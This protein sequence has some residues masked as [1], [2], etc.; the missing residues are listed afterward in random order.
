MPSR[1]L[2]PLFVICWL[3]GSATLPAADAPRIPP[4]QVPPGFDVELVAGP[5]LV[6]HPTMACFDDQ[7]RLY[8]CDGPGMNLP[9]AQLLKELPNCIRRLEDTD[10]DGRYDRSVMFADK[11]TFPMGAQWYQGAV[12]TASPPNIWKLEDRDGDGVAE[13]RTVL[14]SEFG[15]TGNAAD[16]HGC[17]LGPDGRLYWCDGR[18]GH[19]FVDEH[20]NQTKG[21]AARLFRCGLDGKQIESFAGGGMDNP[22]EVTF[23]EQ[24]EPL[25]TVAIFDVVEGRHDALVHWVW[26]GAYPRYEQPCVKEFKRTGDLL[27]P[28]SRFVGVAPS[29]VTRY[30]SSLFGPDYLDNVFLVQFNTHTLVRT[31]ITRD[32]A[33]FRSTDQDFL[34]STDPDFHP[35]DV[36]EDADG[37]LLVIDTGGWFRIGCPTSRIAKPEILGGIYRIRRRGVTPMRD[38]HGR[39]LD[40]AKAGDEQLAERLADARPAVRDQAM[41]ELA[42]HG[43]RAVEALKHYWHNSDDAGGRTRAVWTLARIDTLPARAVI[44]EALADRDAGVRQAAVCAVGTLKDAEA[45]DILCELVESDA[46]PI[47]REAATALGRLGVKDAVPVLLSSLAKVPD[48][49]LEHALI[50]AMIQLDDSKATAAGLTAKGTQVRRAAL[51]AL[52]QMNGGNLRQEQVLPLLN[53]DD[54]ALQRATLDVIER[55]AGWDAETIEVVRRW[56]DNPQLSPEQMGVLRTALVAFGRAP[57]A[58][59][60]VEELLRR[61]KQRREMRLLVLDAVA[62]SELTELPASWVDSVGRDL[63]DSDPQIAGAAL[64]ILDVRHVERFDDRVL[65]LAKNQATP[66]DL[67]LSAIVAY[68]RHGHPLAADAFDLLVKKLSGESSPVDQLAA[69]DALGSAELTPSQREAILQYLPHAGPLELPALVGAFDKQ[70]EP[71]VGRK[72]LDALEQSPGTGNLSVDRLRK[73]FADYPAEIRQATEPLLKRI[74]VDIDKQ[75][76]RLAELSPLLTGGNAATGKQV[77]FGKTA[78]CASCHRVG[79]EGALIGPDL[80]KVGKMRAPRDLLEAVIYPSASF[81]RN[82]ESYTIATS[83]GQVYSGIIS[84]ETTDSVFLR[85]PQRDEIR[86]SR[87]DI[88]QI[89]PSKVSIMPQG[90]DKLLNPSQMRDVF[91][92]LQSLK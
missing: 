34:T 25:G 45:F 84:R 83:S 73:L 88:E 26:G 28:V 64:A 13:K 44:R 80:S 32:G 55:H 21:L 16:I 58:Q 7:G 17:F 36:L 69:A 3:L 10:G 6:Q 67:R 15:F 20:G 5:P 42:S 61:P 89:A 33:T 71:A 30:R 43:P 35:T 51:I 2:G 37:S 1:T 23:T 31:Q 49:F 75:R 53:T 46:P 56:A 38:P 59:A 78:A 14:V 50:Y 85:T 52:D 18:H 76:E 11:M 47:R 74:D 79:N 8:V 54:L 62:R 82:Y 9:A 66:A 68:A 77:F 40:W 12:Y 90:F 91:A 87:A 63:S 22:V 60:L 92:Y 19:N 41:S 86:V 24:G 4:L 65:A 29:G 81:V 48:R 57:R 72:L 70:H 27:P 39:K